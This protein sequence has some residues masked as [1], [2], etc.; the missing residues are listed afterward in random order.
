MKHQSPLLKFDSP[1]AKDSVV[2]P[3]AIGGTPPSNNLP[4]LSPEQVQKDLIEW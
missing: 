2:D 4:L 3:F 1:V